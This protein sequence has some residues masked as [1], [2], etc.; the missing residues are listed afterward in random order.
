MPTLKVLLLLLFIFLIQSDSSVFS[1]PENPAA[2]RSMIERFKTDA[3]GPYK[4]IRWFCKD[5]TI[6]EARD[7]CPGIKQG[8]QHASLKPE[9]I[10]LAEDEH[11]FLGQILATTDH[12]DF[13]D[14]GNDHSRLKQ[15]QLERY[16][17]NIDDGWVNRRA[18]YYRGAMQEEDE[19]A[20]GLDF[21]QWLLSDPARLRSHFFLI[22]ESAKDIPHADETNNTQ[23]V[24]A[25]SLEIAEAMP[26]FQDIRIKIHGMPSAEDIVRIREFRDKN[27]DKLSAGLNDKL[28]KLIS[29]MQIMFRPFRVSDFDQYLRR[30]PQDGESA[31]A[32]ANFL[33]KYPTMDCPPE[34]CQLISQTALVLRKDIVQPMKASARLALL[35][36]SN[37]MEALLNK[38]FTRWKIEYLS[39]L[40]DQVYCLSEAATAFG[41]IELW[42]W[43]QIQRETVRSQEGDTITMQQLSDYSETARK[44]AEWATGTVRAEYMPVIDLFR[45]FEPLANRFYD[46]R[47][48]S[49]VLLY[50][51]LTV[52]RLG[53][54]FAIK[55]GL[56]NDVM[57]IRG[58]SSMRGLNPG[59]TIG[60]LVVVTGSPDAIDISPDKIYIFNN[61]PANLKPVAGIATVTEGNMVSHIQLLARNLGIPNAV[62][63]RENMDDLKKFN[64]DEIFYAVSNKGTVIMKQK[65]K[66]TAQE[67]K[68]FE[69]KK[70][71]EEKISVPVEKMELYNPRI[72]DMK[73]IN[74]THSGIVSGPK[75]ANL[76]QLKQMF[77]DHVVEGLVLPFSV[78]RQHM[79]QTIPGTDITYWMK[80][81]RIFDHA[82]CLRCSNFGE[83]EVEKHILEQLDTLRTLIKKMPLLPTFRSDLQQQ[84]QSVFGKPLGKVPVF[85]RSDTNMEDLKDFTGAGLNLTVFNVVDAEKIFQGI[86]DVWASPYSERSYKW[87][88]RY[89]NNPENVFPSIV[90]IPSVDGD[91]SGVMITKGVTSR[92]EEDLTVAFNRGVGGA[93]DGQAA[94]SWLLTADGKEYLVSPAREINYLTIPAS[95]GSVKKQTRFEK[96]ILTPENLA[97]LRAMAKEIETKLPNVPGINTS[98][99]WDIELGFKDNKIWLFQVRPFVENKQAAASEYLQSITPTFERNRTLLL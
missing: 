65:S 52:S 76:G 34:Q 41:F 4:D 78:F 67:K 66:M 16:L 24:R 96:R 1:Q 64:G 88:Q 40:L 32:L 36:A 45:E 71:N 58:Q 33:N 80:M 25:L 94:E 51:G 70:R 14:A 95:G 12:D 2:I 7:P 3:R 73:T 89:L 23:E 11:I 48:R 99:P 63:S 28:N 56:A 6:R 97:A 93:V 81:I 86:K 46:D 8:N 20:W 49:S 84:F 91:Y 17:R 22:R 74:A 62:I 92:N 29:G 82:E 69:E 83:A 55:A 26:S 15:Y 60:E 59:Y 30:I 47:V 87:R 98:G 79:N 31:K 18:Q 72:I 5:G 61:P 50:L 13:W 10:A 90:I 27:K 68:L 54:E 35:D 21:Y 75:A 43:D 42:E 85:I 77:P 37:K 19:T 53:D 38:E 57:G 39:E 44:V 9:V